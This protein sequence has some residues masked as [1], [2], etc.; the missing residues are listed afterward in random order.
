[1]AL[2]LVEHG[3]ELRPLHP[4]IIAGPANLKRVD[5]CSSFGA[6]Q[7]GHTLS[8]DS[9]VITRS[10]PVADALYLALFRIVAI[11]ELEG[12]ARAIE[13]A[14]AMLDDEHLRR[15]FIAKASQA[16]APVLRFGRRRSDAWDSAPAG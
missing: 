15:A 7:A 16:E 10:A 11:A 3:L 14:D 4:P 2:V 12:A 6:A 9:P 8:M 1:V 13:W 5:E